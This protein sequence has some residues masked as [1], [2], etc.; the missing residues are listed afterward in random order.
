MAPFLSCFDGPRFESMSRLQSQS[1]LS[2]SL[3]RLFVLSF[4]LLFNDQAGGEGVKVLSN[5]SYQCKVYV[6]FV[7]M[8]CY[9]PQVTSH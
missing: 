1:F 6:A 3:S 9:K 8:L 7:T 4:W 2:S 5:E